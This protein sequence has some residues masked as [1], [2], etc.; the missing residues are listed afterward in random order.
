MY[1]CYQFEAIV[2]NHLL[3]YFTYVNLYE[4]LYIYLSILQRLEISFAC[5]STAKALEK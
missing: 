2:K 4:N 3:D 5:A 1:S